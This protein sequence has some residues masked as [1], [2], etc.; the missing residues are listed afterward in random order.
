[1]AFIAS[2]SMESEK[3]TCR[4]R[5]TEFYREKESVWWQG[6]FKQSEGSAI[7]GGGS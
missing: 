2:K 3:G 7:G 1:M 5:K 6:R 4:R